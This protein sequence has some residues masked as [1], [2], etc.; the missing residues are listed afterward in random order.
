MSGRSSSSG[1]NNLIT[2][3]SSNFGKSGV[4]ELYRAGNLSAPSGMVFLSASP[5]E[6]ASYAYM[7]IKTKNADGNG[8]RVQSLESVEQYHVEINNPLVVNESSDRNNVIAAWS[9][10]H[11]NQDP[12]VRTS[13]LPARQWQ[14]MDRQ[15]AQVLNSGD[16]LMTPSFTLD[17]MGDMKSK[18]RLHVYP[19]YDERILMH[20]LVRH[21]VKVVGGVL[22]VLLGHLIKT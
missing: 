14:R 11:P 3:T 18:Y 22:T 19:H 16:S 13:G 7:G 6:S 1:L 2:G 21:L 4:Y 8:Y 20:I 5:E 17:P 9:A 12:K 15:N 10:L